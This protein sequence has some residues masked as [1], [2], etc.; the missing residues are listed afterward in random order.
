MSKSSEIQTE[1]GRD[2]TFTTA[3]AIGVGT[4]I[5]AGIFTLSGLAIRNVG[6]AAI[7]S[8]VLAAMVSL[9][10]ALT[11]CEFVS[12]YPKSGEGYL[13][14]R[15]TFSAPLAY[16]VGWALFLGY[17]SSCSFYI[18]SLSSY[19]IEFIIETPVQNISGILFLIALVFLNIKGT[20]ESGKFQVIVTIAKVLL[21]VWFIVGGL[22]FVS[23]TE[24]ID[25][26]NNDV[27]SIVQT[28]ALVFITFFGFSAIAATAGEVV[29][30]V[31][32]IPK[33]IF[34][35]VGIVSVLYIFV[36]AVII[37]A[38]LTEYTEA[39]MGIAAKKFLGGIG[40]MV[41]VGG[42][43]FSMISASNASIMAGSRV[44]L[45]MSQ[46]G[47]LPKE[48]G[49]INQK[50]RTPIIAL[51][52]VGGL[53]GIFTIALSL[54][55]LAHFADT[56][57]LF[58]LIMVNIAL[59]L[60]RR[61]FPDIERPFKVPLVPFLPIL[62]I[63]ANGY[64]LSQMFHHILPLSLAV[65][66]LVVGFLGFLAWKGAESDAESIPGEHSKLA[67]ERRAG[68]DS[69]NKNKILIPVANP[70]SLPILIKIAANLA[71]EKDACL[72][73]LRVVTVPKQMPL[74]YDFEGKEEEQ[75]ILEAAEKEA[76]KYNVPTIS[77]LR[78]AHNAAR[79]ILESA[80]DR[81][82][83]LIL[84]GWKGYS[85]SADKILGRTTDAVVNYAKRDIML[86]KIA[87]N[88]PIQKVLLPT[89]GGKHAREA[90]I[91]A[92]SLV[93]AIG[94]DL[95][96][97]RVVPS[98]DIPDDDMIKHEKELQEAQSRIAKFNGV[99]ANTKIIFGK[100]IPEAIEKESKNYDTTFVGATRDSI[101]QQVLFGSIPEQLATILKTN[102]VVVKH[103]SAVRALWGKVVSE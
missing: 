88:K 22:R 4:M 46:L 70:A 66:A 52:I 97:C 8:F 67:L 87:K 85:T 19:F 63:L 5:A 36:V 68:V 96:L 28:S 16:L 72:I 89:A 15:K 24:M 27:V 84:L 103:H 31:K 86:V 9:F 91:Y 29:N 3:L 81:Q 77:V 59:I 100:S 74:G 14:A 32:N 35:A 92:A 98:K 47:H 73:F 102:I 95:T 43:L 42:A 38:D 10:T 61:K 44:A 39:A 37:A 50:T 101:Y 71:K 62:G 90:E 30:P 55:D 75:V 33:A 93:H 17:I 76:R 40:G 23:T 20:K 65:G 6:S 48:V 51:F 78:I 64:L 58:A 49:A 99:G 54:E 45:S 1:L 25:K 94:G 57:L 26:F 13:Y 82:C 53:I 18:S 34:W 79:A 2:L 80:K 11:Y 60:H 7:L 69:D 12:I 83:Q 56:V 41:I 21:L